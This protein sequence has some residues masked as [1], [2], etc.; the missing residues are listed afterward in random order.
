[1]TNPLIR[2]AR[3]DDAETIGDIYNHYIRNTHVTF[4]MEAEPLDYWERW[5]HQ[6]DETGPYRLLVADRGQVDGFASS[7]RFKDR[8][9]YDQTVMT[10]VYLRPVATGEGLG[11]KL[12]SAL[13]DALATETVHRALAWIALPN[14]ASVSLHKRFG[15][16]ETGTM[17]EVGYKF[18][19]YIDVL[20]MER[21]LVWKR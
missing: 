6:F 5:M 17:T 16:K 19:Q 8:G 11:G 14:D 13:F 1:M 4:D 7:T 15:F 9:G 10:S 3:P 18:D 20:M 21:A 2:P 12:Y